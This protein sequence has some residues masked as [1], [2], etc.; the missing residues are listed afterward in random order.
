[1]TI[2]NSV[3]VR[4]AMAQARET[5]IGASPSLVFRSGAKPANCAAARTGTVLATMTLPA[6]WASAPSSGTAGLLGTWQDPSVDATGTIGYYSIEQGGTCHEQGTVTA[7]G[8]GGDIE[9]AQATTD[10]VAGQS[11]TI[12]AYNY[13]QGGA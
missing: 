5:T 9:L 8:G 7:T 6:D 13:T 4:N 1:M 3:A 2:Q 10:V 12:S 11:F